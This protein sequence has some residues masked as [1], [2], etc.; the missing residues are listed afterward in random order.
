MVRMHVNKMTMTRIF[1][2]IDYPDDLAQES[3]KTVYK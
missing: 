2:S 3:Q 1:K